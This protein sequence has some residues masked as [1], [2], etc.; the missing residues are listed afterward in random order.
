MR[1]AE[2]AARS[3]SAPVDS[4][5]CDGRRR[6]GPSASGPS[7]G[8]RLDELA[9]QHPLEAERGLVG[10]LVLGRPSRT[11]R[12]QR[13]VGDLRQA[14][15]PGRSSLDPVGDLH[16]L[17]R[18][19]DRLATRAGRRA[20]TRSSP[21][22]A[23][24]M[25]TL[26]ASSAPCVSV[27]ARGAAPAGAGGGGGYEGVVADRLQAAAASGRSRASSLPRR[28]PP[29]VTV[30]S[31]ADRDRRSRR[32]PAGTVIAGW[33]SAPVDVARRPRP[34][35]CSAPSRVSAWRPSA[36]RTRRKPSPWIATSSGWSVRCSA[37]WANAAAGVDRRGAGA[38]AHAVG[39][40]AAG[41][42]V[43]EVAEADAHV[44]VARRVR[45][46]QVVGDGVDALLLGRHA[47]G[48]GVQSFEHASRV[49][50][51]ACGRN[52]SANCGSGTWR[53]VSRRDGAD[54]RRRPCRASRRWSG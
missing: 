24:A 7:V 30:P 50:R 53:S 51:P 27:V 52:L 39:G 35:T 34:S 36:Q 6:S 14:E 25:S 31:A 41:L 17:V 5:S 38:G 4:A 33:T 20:G 46:R 2:A 43:D 44:L 18:R 1:E 9:E 16:H 40:G 54:L 8:H 21:T 47:G 19:L 15:R 28:R 23:S 37:P 26:E 49:R 10:L 13:G 3:A 48:G 32:C 42:R 29:A 11:S 22:I 45:V 12:G